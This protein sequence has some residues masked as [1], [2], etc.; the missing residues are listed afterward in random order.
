MRLAVPRLVACQPLIVVDAAVVA[1]PPIRASG[2]ESLAAQPRTSTIAVTVSIVGRPP[3]ES[4]TD[5]AVVEVIVVMDEVI[6]VVVV[7]ITVPVVAMPYRSTVPAT[8]T[9]STNIGKMSTIYSA[10]VTFT[11]M[12][13]TASLHPPHDV[14]DTASPPEMDAAHATSEASTASG[15]GTIESDWDKEQAARKG[16]HCS[17]TGFHD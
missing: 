9:P 14:A 6:V 11:N 1:V 10:D 3:T 12:S 17:D 2:N 13:D 7:P 5:K 15:I 4:D 16:S 8:T